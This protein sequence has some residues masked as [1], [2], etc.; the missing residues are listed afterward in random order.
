MA[1]IF[2]AFALAN[3]D[4]TMLNRL[5]ASSVDR[6]RALWQGALEGKGLPPTSPG[7]WAPKRNINNDAP[8]RGNLLNRAIIVHSCTQKSCRTQRY[9]ESR[10]QPALEVLILSDLS[11]LIIVPVSQS[12]KSAPFFFEIRIPATFRCIN[13]QP[14]PS[15]R[16]VREH[17]C[18]SCLFNCFLP[19]ERQTAPFGSIPERKTNSCAQTEDYLAQTL[20]CRNNSFTAVVSAARRVWLHPHLM[21]RFLT[22]SMWKV[23]FT[24]SCHKRQKPQ[25]QTPQAPIRNRQT[26]KVSN[27]NR[28]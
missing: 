8:L 5:L 11:T 21:I 3:S 24:G 1:E 13:Y 18:S 15:L 10:I 4:R 7:P 25:A 2:D 9:Q 23:E 17:C 14:K 19:N 28:S 22:Q 20:W 16:L 6:T 26:R 27:A 12:N